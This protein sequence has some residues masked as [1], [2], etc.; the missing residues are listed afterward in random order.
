MLLREGLTMTTTDRVAFWGVYS[1]VCL[2][3]DRPAKQE[4]ATEYF[5][6][7]KELPLT[8]VDEAARQVCKSSSYFPRPVH[9][10]E[11]A[12][13]LEKPKPGFAKER[14]VQ[15]AEGHTVQTYICARC[16]DCGWRPQCGCN[17]DQMFG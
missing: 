16:E 13:L 3:W 11:A 1:R 6:A 9:W 2:L 17:L 4:M 10:L 15:T 14:W 5:E 8:I 12:Y 7:L